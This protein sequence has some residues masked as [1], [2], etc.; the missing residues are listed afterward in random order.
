MN[1]PD[2]STS[3]PVAANTAAALMARIQSRLPQGV[4]AVPTPE[5]GY[6]LS[7]TTTGRRAARCR[8]RLVP[9]TT[10]KDR[11]K[12]AAFFYKPSAV[13]HSGDRY[14]YGA[15][16]FDDKVGLDRVDRWLDWLLSG[17][18]PDQIP[19]DIRRALTFDLPE[20]EP[21]EVAAADGP[22]TSYPMREAVELAPGRRLNPGELEIDLFCRGIRIDDSCSLEE[23]ARVFSRTRAGLGSGLELI[24]PGPLKE[25]WMNVPVEE[26]FATDS[27][28]RI[29][30]CGPG[31][32]RVVDDRTLDGRNPDDLP[33]LQYKIK[34]PHEP[35]WYNQTT[36]KGTLMSRVGVLQG[37]YLGIYISNSCGFWYHKPEGGCHFCT[38]GLN[39]GVNEVAEKDPDDVVDVARA[40][41]LE[42]GNTFVHFNSGFH[43]G[44]KNLEVVAPYVKA[45]K[46]QVGALIGVQVIPSTN[47]WKYD[48]LIDMGTNHFS[49]CYEFHNP[50]YFAKLLPGKERLVGQSTFFK[51]ME[52]CTKKLGPGACSGEIIAGVEPLEDTL[53]AIDY[54]TDVGA[55]PTVCIF[56]PTIGARMEHY[57]SPKTEEMIEVMRYMYEAC[58]KRGIPIGITP[59]IEVSLIVNPEDAR[60]LVTPTIASRLYDARN[61]MMRSMLRPYFNME[62]RPRPVPASPTDSSPYQP[63]GKPGRSCRNR[64][65]RLF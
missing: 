47:L 18:H 51:A 19:D 40:A 65:Q 53:K 8:V 29:V 37:T 35:A 39:V 52:Y 7:L 30:R 34:L 44:D 42:S 57:P 10:G 11:G 58:R 45:V 17:F 60:Y 36:R 27:P 54:I 55:F 63:N 25:L 61:A 41:R 56:R 46:E 14:S 15:A 4:R 16:V 24:V 5:G 48:W 32:Y 28:Y 38:T 62:M 9:I 20:F 64:L 26:D 12:A 31:D 50:D 13:P 22:V 43:G 49:F 33:R 3:T 21:V 23:D 1:A 2:S 6:E 59:N